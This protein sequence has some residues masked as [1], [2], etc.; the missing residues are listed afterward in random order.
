MLT[1]IVILYGKEVTRKTF[2][3]GNALIDAREWIAGNGYNHPKYELQ[4]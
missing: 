1:V 4:D 3:G 2:N